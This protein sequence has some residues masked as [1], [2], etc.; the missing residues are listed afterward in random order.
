MLLLLGVDDVIISR[1][2]QPKSEFLDLAIRYERQNLL[3]NWVKPV[4][5]STLIG[6]IDRATSLATLE[7]D[8]NSPL[9]FTASMH[10]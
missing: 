10:V 3:L 1:R 7:N 2:Y 9:S 6:R 5:Y 8:Q 4:E